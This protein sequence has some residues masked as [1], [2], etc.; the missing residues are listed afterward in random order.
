MVSFSASSL[1]ASYGK[2]VTL[3]RVAINRLI[4]NWGDC[5][6]FSCNHAVRVVGLER[7]PGVKDMKP[8]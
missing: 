2:I 7:S 1:E 8:L 3:A 5:K 6:A 4:V